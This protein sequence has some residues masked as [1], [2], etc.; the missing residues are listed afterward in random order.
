M[1]STPTGIVFA[2]FNMPHQSGT[3]ITVDKS[4]LTHL[5]PKIH[6]SQQCSLLLLYS[7]W[8]WTRVQWHVST[9]WY[10][11][12]KFHT[13]KSCATWFHPSLPQL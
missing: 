3:F 2:V 9:R 5:S 12:E 11:T 13:L 1:P 7:L 4:V 10:D 6:S 8:V